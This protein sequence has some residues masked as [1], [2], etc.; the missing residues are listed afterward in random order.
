MAMAR[1]SEQLRQRIL[2]YLLDR[3]HAPE[4]KVPKLG[5]IAQ[6]LGASEE[7]ISDQLDILDDQ[8]A[9]KAN[10]TLGGGARPLLTGKGKTMLEELEEKEV[11]LTIKTVQEERVSGLPI[12]K[13]FEWDA[14]VSHASEDK[15][16]FVRPLVQELGS[17]E[18][19]L[20]YDEFTLSVGDS[21][22]RSIDKGLAKSRYG[23]VVLSPCFFDKEWPQ[24]ELDG[25]AVRERNGQKVIL[26]VW[27]DVN[28]ED[29]A[30]YSL[31]LA[32]RVAAKANEGLNKVVAK[33]LL[34]LKP[35]P[36]TTLN[37]KQQASVGICRLTKAEAQQ[38]GKTLSQ[39]VG[40]EYSAEDAS[41]VETI[42]G[43]AVRMV[44]HEYSLISEIGLMLSI[45]KV[46][47]DAAREG[48]ILKG[49][50]DVCLF[51]E[52][53]VRGERPHIPELEA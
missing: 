11:P 6:N 29:V 38:M 19:R 2:R 41:A 23:I 51:A 39:L 37:N 18:V 13:Q 36:S 14:F 12:E 5:E 52:Q 50:P 8:G 44:V 28:A 49:N 15:D 1:M 27:L 17:R 48:F 43:R 4:S 34:V 9:I 20:W 32:D 31:P 7:E 22:H 33:L 47:T 3:E 53:L 10:R 25:L 16:S 40:L 26:P 42:L 35:M 45:F 46:E 30:H 24:R 21:L